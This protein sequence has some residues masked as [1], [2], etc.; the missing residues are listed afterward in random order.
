M[1]GTIFENLITATASLRSKTPSAQV[2][3]LKTKFLPALKAKVEVTTGVPKKAYSYAFNT[4]ASARDGIV[5]G[6]FTNKDFAGLVKELRGQHKIILAAQAAPVKSSKLSDEDQ[7]RADAISDSGQGRNGHLENTGRSAMLKYNKF[8]QLVPKTIKKKFVA[9]KIP[10]VAVTNPILTKD[11]LSKYR[12]CDDTIFGYPFIKDQMLV[13]LNMDWVVSDFKR[14]T[15]PA[16]DTLLE[17]LKEQTGK[18]YT[19]L[20]VTKLRGN[21]SWVWLA[22]E[23]TMQRLNQAAYGG[24]FRVIG[25]DLPFEVSTPSTKK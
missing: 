16:I 17:V 11:R 3:L 6:A 14:Q 7:K 20:G 19:Q 1:H 22:N 4:L 23:V 12:L 8:E 9:I 18:K 5:S 2:R 21:V 15:K 13:G 25:W 24:H 10:V